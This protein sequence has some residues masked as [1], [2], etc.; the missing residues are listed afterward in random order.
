MFSGL[1]ASHHQRVP[2]R[3]IARLPRVVPRSLFSRALLIVIMPLRDPPGGARLRLLRAPLGLGDPLARGRL[4]GRG[5]ADGRAA[6]GG[7]DRGAPRAGCS[8]SP[9]STSTSRSR[10][11]P[12]ARLRPAVETSGLLPSAL[13]RRLAGDLRERGAPA[14]RDRHPPGRAAAADRR[15]RPARGRPA[16][17]ARAP[18]AGRQ[19]HH[20]GVHRLDGRP[21]AA[22]A[23]PRDLLHDPPGAA[24]PA[25]RLGGRQLR[26]G[27]RR[28]RLQARRPDRDPP[29][30]ARPST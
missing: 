22:A 30:R 4:L 17:R 11:S 24:D 8:T 21:V 16:A 6:R 29:A 13:D 27:P 26:Q 3:R 14:V 25:A 10:W 20:P 28:R 23:D 18:Q 19:H 12:R 2:R 15:L 1:A 9:A 7:E 5:R